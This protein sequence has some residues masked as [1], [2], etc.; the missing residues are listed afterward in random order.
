M[1]W[2][3][4]KVSPSDMHVF[5]ASL[6]SLLPAIL[7]YSRRNKILAVLYTNEWLHLEID[8]NLNTSH[9]IYTEDFLFNKELMVFNVKKI[10][11]T[12]EVKIEQYFCN[13]KKKLSWKTC[14]FHTI[15]HSN[16]IVNGFISSEHTRFLVH[17]LLSSDV[18]IWS[19]L[20][21]KQKWLGPLLQKWEKF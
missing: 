12:S 6:A 2:K 7:T 10:T 11:Y 13:N 1:F 20:S 4:T 18:K 19:R 5:P 15:H 14:H 3:G 21:V 9:G 16:C 17:F 8:K